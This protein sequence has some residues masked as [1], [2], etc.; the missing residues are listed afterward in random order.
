MAYARVTVHGLQVTWKIAGI[1][2]V[3]FRLHVSAVSIVIRC[4]PG[5]QPWAVV[6]LVFINDLPSQVHNSKALLYADDLKLFRKVDNAQDCF[7]LQNDVCSVE[8]WCKTNRLQ[9]N[10]KKTSVMSMSRRHECIVFNCILSGSQIQRVSLV[11]DLGVQVD[12][13]L[14]FHQHVFNTASQALPC[15]GVVSRLTR[16][17]RRPHCIRSLCCSLVRQRLEFRS[18]I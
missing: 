5:L 8:K 4:A 17:F 13:R 14:D 3:F 18:V 10:L 1:E 6:V 7:L 2:L 11:R 9:L 12:S 15:L 16:R